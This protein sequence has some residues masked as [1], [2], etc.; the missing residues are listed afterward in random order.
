M[1]SCSLVPHAG[2]ICQ[3]LS[4]C[5]LHTYTSKIWQDT[6]GICRSSTCSCNAR[7]GVTCS[8]VSSTVGW[9]K[10]LLLP[11][12]RSHYFFLLPA[13]FCLFRSQCHFC[14]LPALLQLLS[15]LLF[16]VVLLLRRL[17]PTFLSHTNRSHCSSTACDH[18]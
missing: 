13:C 10:P 2:N 1:Q 17:L 16:V 12:L 15:L 14:G 9:K 4:V 3:T 5:C 11:N 18:M 6:I 7:G 8:G